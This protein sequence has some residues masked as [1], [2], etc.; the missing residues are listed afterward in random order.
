LQLTMPAELSHQARSRPVGGVWWQT[1]CCCQCCDT[2]MFRWISPI[3]RDPGKCYTN[4]RVLLQQTA[5]SRS[6]MTSAIS[7]DGSICSW[8]CFHCGPLVNTL[9]Q[10]SASLFIP[11]QM[12]C[13]PLGFSK[14]F[15]REA[16]LQAVSNF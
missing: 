13:F 5:D 6:C 4:S 2:R 14:L 8:L 12:Q 16:N 10:G 11:K 7:V 3:K 9:A 1:L 15:A